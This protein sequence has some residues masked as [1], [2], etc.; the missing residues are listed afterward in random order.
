MNIIHHFFTTP[1]NGYAWYGRIAIGLLMSLIVVG[2]LLVTPQKLRRPMILSVTFFGGLFFFLEFFW[3]VHAMP[4]G[5][6]PT[7]TGNFLTPFVLPF[8]NASLVI[9]SFAVGMGVINLFQIHGRRV[10]RRGAGWIN[11]F[12]FFVAL[13][14]MLIIGILNKAHPNSINKNL[15]ELLVVGALQSLDATMFSII[16]FYIVSAAY[17]AFRVR[18]VEAT[19]LLVTAVIVM[20]GQI[21]IGQLLTAWIPD[22]AMG[23]LG[24]DLHIEV[25]RNWILTKANAPATRAIAFGLGIGSLAVALRIWLGLERGSY[26]EG[27]G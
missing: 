16:A 23:G 27:Q 9:G 26:F 20:L 18:S 25:I 4:T 22:K 1:V 5:D 24:H 10:A 12:A 13:F 11:S 17:R 19:M 14:L 8:A 6:D 21:S 7:A 15:N 3:P 2:L